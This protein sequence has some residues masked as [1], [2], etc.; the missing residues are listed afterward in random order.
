VGGMSDKTPEQ[1]FAAALAAFQSDVPAIRKE[2]TAT[3]RS[4]KGN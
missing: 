4:D 1:E 3:V 2:N